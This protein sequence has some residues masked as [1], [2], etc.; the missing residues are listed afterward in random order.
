MEKLI[1]LIGF[2]GVGKS[3]V[4]KRLARKM[5]RSFLDTDQLIEEQFNCTISSFFEQYGEIHFRQVENQILK[6]LIAQEDHALVAVGGGLPCYH[7]NMQL[8]NE[9]GVTIYLYRPAKE[10]FQRLRQNK[11]KRPLIVQKSDE[12]LLKFI[13]QK[14]SER[15]QFYKKATII[16]N[17]HQQQT[18]D[19][20]ELLER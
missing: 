7:D 20:I 16:A 2:M 19:L 1:F 14:L 3:T 11:E 10:L 6:Q 17:R 5:G 12:E 4:G 15:E 8:M 18:D 13:E 9:Y